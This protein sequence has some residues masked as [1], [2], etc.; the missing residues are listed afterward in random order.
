MNTPPPSDP[1]LAQLEADAPAFK[2]ALASLSRVVGPKTRDHVILSYDE[3]GLRLETAGAEMA[4]PATGRWTGQARVAG[5]ALLRMHRVLPRLGQLP[6]RVEEEKLYLGGT[7]LPCIWE[8]TTQPSIP[9]PL[10]LTDLDVLKLARVYPAERLE[11][12]G[13]GTRVAD[14]EAWLASMLDR[15]ANILEP[16]GIGRETLEAL[17]ERRLREHQTV[18]AVSRAVQEGLELGSTGDQLEL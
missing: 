10:N 16:L 2:S 9:L 11:A 6:I 5:A 8:E 15:A 7:A 1:V 17:A 4:V 12:A 18:Q 13:I 14:A 3:D